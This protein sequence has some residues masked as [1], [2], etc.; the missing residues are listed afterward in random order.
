MMSTTDI[1]EQLKQLSN[2]DHL[3]VIKAVTHLVREGLLAESSS[4]RE[5]QDRRLRA[6]AMALKDLYEPDGELTEWASLD[7][8]AR[9]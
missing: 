4:A 1:I 5:E 7:T 3:A 8:E 6:A 9:I 2:P